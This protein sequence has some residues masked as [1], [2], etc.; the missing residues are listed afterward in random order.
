MDELLKQGRRP[1]AK[2]KTT[3]EVCH[4]IDIDSWAREGLPQPGRIRSGV[5]EWRTR[6]GEEVTRLAYALDMTN[7]H[8]RLQYTDVKTGG[9]VDYRVRLVSTRLPSGGLCWW[10]KCPLMVAAR[11]CPQR[12]R[13]LYLPPGGKYFMCRHC[14]RLSYTSQRQDAITRGP[15][16]LARAG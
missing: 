5:R 2:A 12:V 9:H 14:W 4:C 1:S 16:Q 8:V 3:V 7:P 10:F 15:Q 11:E 13:K 6:G